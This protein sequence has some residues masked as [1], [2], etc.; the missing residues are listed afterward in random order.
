MKL[1]KL[2]IN[3]DQLYIIQS[4]LECYSRLGIGQLEMVFA[5]L[6]FKT[7]GQFKNSVHLLQDPEVKNAINVLKFKL[8]EMVFPTARSMNSDRVHKDFKAAHD[9]YQA[10]S[11]RVEPAEESLVIQS[12]EKNK[13]SKDTIIEIELVEVKEQHSD[14]KEE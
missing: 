8:F 5:S 11:K 7:Y 4:A 1:Y 3:E 13:I 9:L 12:S 2:L 14:E 6:G 10:I